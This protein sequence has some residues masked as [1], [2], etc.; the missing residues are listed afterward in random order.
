MNYRAFVPAQRWPRVIVGVSGVLLGLFLLNAGWDLVT[1]G[2][3]GV[4][5]YVGALTG[6]PFILAIG[7]AGVWLD[8]S[9]IPAHRHRRIA[10]WLFGGIGAFL[11]INLLL[12]TIF[13]PRSLFSYL[14]WA[15]WAA[16][17]GGGVGVFIGL[18]EARAIDRELTA[19]RER[20][21]NQELAAQKDRLE[22]FAGILSHDL[23]NP[24]NVAAGNVELANAD[25]DDPRLATAEAALERMDALVEQTLMLARS[26]RVIGDTDPVD[27]SALADRCWAHVDTADAN[28]VLDDL[29]TV[30]AD[31]DRLQQL[32][33]NLFRNSV[34]HGGRDVTVTIGALADGFYVADDGVGMPD[35]GDVFSVGVS[36][37]ADGTGF[38]LAIVREIADAHGWTVTATES[39]SGGARFEFRDVS[40][41]A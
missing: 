19:E 40:R 29:P 8:G 21:R 30:S 11:S 13:P 7:Y 37:N 4:E 34:E 39:E 31:P 6:L 35:D 20:V 32:L 16:A 27:L 36:T 22:E 12:M 14:G 41:L 15:R 3:L 33:E 38:G 23:R 18:F 24:L 5:F 1:G 17:L 9:G 28:L 26:G 25:H 10:G 2:P